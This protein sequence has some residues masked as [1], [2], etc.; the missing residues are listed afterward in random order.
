[1][2]FAS[3][4]SQCLTWRQGGEVLPQAGLIWLKM[5][6]QWELNYEKST[7]QMSLFGVKIIFN[8]FNINNWQARW[9]YFLTH[10]IISPFQFASVK[11]PPRPAQVRLECSGWRKLCLNWAMS[12]FTMRKKTKEFITNRNVVANMNHLEYTLLKFLSWQ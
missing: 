1:M 12:Y 9:N 6:I 10:F 3:T 4:H 2:F 11:F 7:F 8:I 5:L